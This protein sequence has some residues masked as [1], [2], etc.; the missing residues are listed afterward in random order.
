MYPEPF[1]T[2]NRGLSPRKELRKEP[3]EFSFSP[4]SL[5]LLIRQ[6]KLEAEARAVY[7]RGAAA[8][9]FLG[10]PSAG[11]SAGKEENRPETPALP[12]LGRPSQGRLHSEGLLGSGNFLPLEKSLRL[13]LGSALTPP[14]PISG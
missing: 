14:T 12:A 11:C 5:F 7:E 6:R 10:V 4:P 2:A 8:P 1:H 3:S 13:L 9:Q